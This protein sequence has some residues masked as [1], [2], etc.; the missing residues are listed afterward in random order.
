MNLGRCSTNLA[1]VSGLVL[2]AL[3]GSLARA[4]TRGETVGDG[5]WGQVFVLGVAATHRGR[6]PLVL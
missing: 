5:P 4:L 2:I 6:I 1:W 3:A